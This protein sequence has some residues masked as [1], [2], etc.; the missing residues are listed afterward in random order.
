MAIEIFGKHLEKKSCFYMT[1]RDSNPQPISLQ[2]YTQPFS[3]TGHDKNTESW[4][5][6]NTQSCFYQKMN[7][8]A[9]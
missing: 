1:E 2:R 5:G 4:Q 9:L 7:F 8:I 3:K 6:K